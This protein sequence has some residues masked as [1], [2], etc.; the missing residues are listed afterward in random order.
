MLLLGLEVEAATFLIM[1]GALSLSLTTE[2]SLTPIIMRAHSDTD[3]ML[4]SVYLFLMS[5]FVVTYFLSGGGG[6]GT[7]GVAGT[8]KHSG[9]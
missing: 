4:P 7:E 1:S 2:L 3:N 5:Q 6:G 8:P 9:E